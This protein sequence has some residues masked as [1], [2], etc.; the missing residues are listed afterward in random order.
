[1]TKKFVPVLLR[2]KVYRLLQDDIKKI[3]YMAHVQR[4]ALP[5]FA[6]QNLE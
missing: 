4:P 2:T 6:H 1:M 5:K 3:Y